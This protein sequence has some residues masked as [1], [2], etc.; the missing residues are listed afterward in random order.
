MKLPNFS[1]DT[2]FG[3]SESMLYSVD[4][5]LS[6]SLFARLRHFS[7]WTGILVF[8]AGL[9]IL[10]ERWLQLSYLSDYL[11]GAYKVKIVTG[12]T[13]SLSGLALTLHHSAQNHSGLLRSVLKWCGLSAAGFIFLLSA[14]AL[15]GYVSAGN[16]ES[17]QRLFQALAEFVQIPNVAPMS[18]ASSFGFLLIGLALASL[19]LEPRKW[20][21]ASQVL[22]LG[23][24]VSGFVGFLIHLSDLPSLSELHFYSSMALHT[25][26]FQVS[27]VLGVLCA[28][29]ESALMSEICG[30]R[31]GALMARRLLPFVIVA[32]V[33]LG[34]AWRY[35]RRSGFY[36]TEVAAALTDITGVLLLCMV[37]WQ[38][39]KR[40]NRLDRQRQQAEERDA[41]LA[42]IVDCAND[43]IIGRAIDGTIRSCNKT[44][45]RLLGYPEAELLGKPLTT[46]VST[47]TPNDGKKPVGPHGTDFVSHT[48]DVIRARID[49]RILDV[50]MAQSPVVDRD[51]RALGAAVVIDDITQQERNQAL[52]DASQSRLHAVLQSAMDAVIIIDSQQKIV[53]FNQAA[54]K[55]FG[56][57]AAE[58]V[59]ES[60]GFMLPENAR[61]AHVEH[62]RRFGEAGM[63]SRRMGSLGTV[64]GRRG[65]GDVFPVEASIS[66]FE[67][68]GQRF[69]SA[70]VRD[71]SDRVRTE[72][73]L[74]FAEAQLHSALQAGS[75]ATWSW[76]IPQDTVA[77]NNPL[78][79]VHEIAREDVSDARLK[80]FLSF[81]HSV[82]RAAVEKAI[83]TSVRLGTP[84]E[85]EY[86]IR[87]AD[88][89]L[90]WIAGR[91]R[92]ERDP[93]DQ[94]L[95]LTGVCQD[96]TARKR[97]EETILQTH[98]M[99]ALGTLA[100]GVAHDFNNILMAIGGNV[101][102]AL[103]E[104]PDDHPV[105]QN[106]DRIEK[107]TN[108]ASNL[109]RQILTFS[110][111]QPPARAVI[112]LAQEVE[113]AV[114]LLHAAL[115]ARV[116][117]RS[118]YLPGIPPVSADAT[119][120]HQI[121]MNLGANAAHA[122]GESSGTIELRLEAA[123]LSEDRAESVGG[124]P[125]GKYARLSVRDNGCGMDKST[126]ARAFEPFFTTKGVG[127]GTGLGLSVV[128]GIM[129][130]HG[131]SVTAYSEVGKGTIF[132]LYFPAAAKDQEIGGSPRTAEDAFSGNGAHILHVDDEEALVLVTRRRL[133]QAGYRVTGCTEPNE[134]LELFRANPSAFDAVITD[135]SMPRMPGAEL[136]RAI[137]Q[138]RSD[139]PVIMA[140]GYLRPED[141]EAA[142]R[143]GVT[144]LISK[145]ADFKDLTRRLHRLLTPDLASQKI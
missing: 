57:T 87:R 64:H 65:D 107:A 6:P 136:V 5:E 81:V 19:L 1:A 123:E 26:V 69:F 129:R 2:T 72:D 121:I 137:R 13:L 50:L 59:G 62:I 102:L 56:Y 95:R 42:A 61:A 113:E 140:S 141:H 80:T 63:T 143:L 112:S 78:L 15:I 110:R 105:C 125:A 9:L 109:V 51:G 103:S 128:H 104:L 36:G 44:A 40:L 46:L 68:G 130:S 90:Q 48:P 145:P 111:R 70:I 93:Q 89:A 100:G 54:E 14:A 98:K 120:V 52:L 66:Q 139:I 71:I 38:A 27:I 74:R 21:P 22:A 85:V 82:D 91:G 115:P 33:A 77:W 127:K 76:D 18:P 99:E 126:L 32:P 132:H 97:L 116:E 142:E 25:S 17:A 96:I 60:L 41:W 119:Q 8:V 7:R 83:E 108:R 16:D 34:W 134:A 39:A 47:E 124:L 35:G 73:A 101:E 138:I 29:P 122:M 88:G 24:G 118:Q 43:A 12:V 86:R 45:E 67:S 117:I 114:R 49:G 92:L 133:E 94:P 3:T 23:A 11:Q 53:L 20:L 10:A 28:R 31:F 30:D 106:L 37:V 144:E 135:L 84:Y 75:M 55:M 131:G 79:H 58:M 4:G